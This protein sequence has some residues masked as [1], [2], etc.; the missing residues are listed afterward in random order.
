V[1]GNWD[2][3][4][5]DTGTYENGVAGTGFSDD[6]PHLICMVLGIPIYLPERTDGEP[7]QRDEAS[8]IKLPTIEQVSP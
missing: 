5:V 8:M 4:K 6:S 1:R 7:C 2:V 3:L